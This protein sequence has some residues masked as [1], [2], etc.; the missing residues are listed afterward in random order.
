MA[1]IKQVLSERRIAYEYAIRQ[2]PKLF[3]LKGAPKPH[4]SYSS[5]ES[6]EDKKFLRKSRM[7]NR[8]NSRLRRM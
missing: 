2:D 4:W 6:Q 5:P 7:G 8:N 3:G 1:R